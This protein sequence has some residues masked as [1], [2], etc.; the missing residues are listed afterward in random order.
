MASKSTKSTKKSKGS[1]TAARRPLK[2]SRRIVNTKRH[3]IG[4]IVGGKTYDLRK[5]NQRASL[6]ELGR[7][8]RISGVRVV[9]KHLQAVP[10]RR[11]LASL[12]MRVER[13]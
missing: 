7:S 10:G 9:G 5:K 1:A 8:N 6:L 13:S 3:T 12:P 4:Y 2:V 11:R